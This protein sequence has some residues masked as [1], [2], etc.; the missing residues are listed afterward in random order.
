MKGEIK[1][2]KLIKLLIPF[3]IIAM[4]LCSTVVFAETKPI[5][6]SSE[7]TVEQTISPKFP[8]TE[9]DDDKDTTATTGNGTGASTAAKTVFNGVF[10]VVKIVCLA[11][12][13]LFAVM[14]IVKYTI[15]HAQ[16]D[17]PSQQ[18]AAMQLAAGIALIVVGFLISTLNLQN[19]VLNNMSAVSLT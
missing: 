8:V 6:T 19:V 3:C 13:A 17:S 5:P 15:A 4:M 10:T 18:K 11:V 2:K 12:G 7:Q 14:G 9:T 16:E 1:M